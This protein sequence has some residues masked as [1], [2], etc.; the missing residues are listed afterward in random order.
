MLALIVQGRWRWRSAWSATPATHTV[1]AT[2]GSAN[3]GSG[4]LTIFRPHVSVSPT[5]GT[6]GTGLT[7]TG[8]GWLPGDLVFVQIG[9]TTFNTDDVC[10]LTVGSDGTIAGNKPGSGC[11]VPNVPAASQP[12]VAIDDQNQGVQATG[13]SFTVT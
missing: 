9:S 6:P 3:T 13:T 1:S 8:G 11:Q 7:V 5:S 2:D 10:E 4:K 12:L